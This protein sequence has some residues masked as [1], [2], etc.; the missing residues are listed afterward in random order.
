MA[1]AA[2]TT[3]RYG[4]DVDESTVALIRFPDERLAHFHSSFGEE[5]LSSLTLFGEE[6][7]LTL[8]PAYRHDVD[9]RL[10]VSRHGRVEE[11]T[12]PPTDQ[13]AAEIGYFSECILT[14]R[15]PEPS[16][17]EGLQDVRTIEA[18]YRSGRDGRPVT[19]PRLARVDTPIATEIDARK[20]DTMKRQAS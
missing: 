7:W 13:Y 18:I 3:R 6:G 12:F 8:S 10:L 4:G 5:P 16:G 20:L 9:T 15:Q 11:T 1:M 19:L 2:R 17:I 14:D